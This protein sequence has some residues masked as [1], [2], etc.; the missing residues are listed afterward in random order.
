M[1]GI[2]RSTCVRLSTMVVPAVLL[3]LH[4]CPAARADWQDDIGYTQLKAELG[5]AVPTGAGVHVAHVE[6]GGPDKSQP[7]FAGKTFTYLGGMA[8][9]CPLPHATSVARFYYGNPD[10]QTPGITQIDLWDSHQFLTILDQNPN[11]AKVV[12]GPSPNETTALRQLDYS[13]ATYHHLNAGSFVRAGNP[14]VLAWAGFNGITVG[15]YATGP[16]T[17]SAVDGHTVTPSIVGPPNSTVSWSVPMV[18]SAAALLLS[19]ANTHGQTTAWDNPD[20]VIKAILMAGARKDAFNSWSRTPTQPLDLAN[21][22]GMLST[23]NSYHILAAGQQAA[24]SS[25]TVTGT[26]WDFAACSATGRKTC[27]FNLPAAAPFTAVLA[28]NRNVNKA[29]WSCTLPH[30]KLELYKAT[31]FTLGSLVDQ[32]VSATDN[33]QLIYETT[34]PPGRYA[35][36]VT[37][38]TDKQNYALAWQTAKVKAGDS[39]PPAAPTEKQAPVAPAETQATAADTFVGT[40]SATLRYKR[41]LLTVG[42]TVYELKAA[43]NADPSV[44]DTLSKISKGEA[45]GTYVFKGT[46]ATVNNRAGLLVNSIT[47]Q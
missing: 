31:D 2:L 38:D 36:V 40:V 32:S 26:G 19:H 41:P 23:D 6:K 5:K 13:I 1:L 22:A 34:L 43:E 27:F 28:W 4:L 10:S 3:V 20:T 30:L 17:N 39:A 25:A 15:N 16:S 37:G 18:S 33:V 11:N 42:A 24:S 29:D 47:K 12:N 8:A 35:M 7:L 9:D 14:Q 45:T 46:K 44:A 21:G